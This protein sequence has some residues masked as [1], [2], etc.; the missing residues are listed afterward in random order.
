[1]VSRGNES[2][3]AQLYIQRAQQLRGTVD[4]ML[5]DT[6]KYAAGKGLKALKRQLTEFSDAFVN[7]RLE[8]IDK[9]DIFSAL[10]QVKRE[11]GRHVDSAASAVRTKGGYRQ[12]NVFTALDELYHGL[13]GDLENEAIWGGAATL[14]RQIN[15]PL[16]DFLGID[17]RYQP[18]LRDELAKNQKE[19]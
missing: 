9:A 3:A 8:A 15:K 14:Q 16:T 17:T 7:K 5:A 12:K 4:G 19:W 2:E 13:R 18:K 1:M 11:L 10:D 6:D